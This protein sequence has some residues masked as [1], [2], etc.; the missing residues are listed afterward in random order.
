MYGFENFSG[1]GYAKAPFSIW[2]Y[3]MSV[4]SPT[5]EFWSER[6]VFITG[7]TGFKG[8]WL[9][10]W[11]H[12]LGAAV[13]GYALEPA[14][15]PNMYDYFG[16]EKLIS[17]SFGDLNDTDKLRVEMNQFAPDVVLHLAA[18]ALVIDSYKSPLETFQTNTLGTAS[19]LDACRSSESVKVIISVATDKVYEN[20][21]EM[22]QFSESDR[23][24]GKDPYSASKAAA[25]LVV[26]A[27]RESFFRGKGVKLASVRAGNV[28]GG[29][30]WA[31]NRIVPDAAR[32]F[33][34]GQGLVV[35][36]P[37]AIRPWQFVLEPLLGYLMVAKACFIDTGYDTAWNF[38]PDDSDVRTVGELADL[39]CSAWGG[40]ASWE[41]AGESPG[42]FKEASVLLLS[43]QQAKERLN[44]QPLLNLEE[45]VDL[46][47]RWYKMFQS[48][49]PA[50]LLE[51]TRT[52][53]EKFTAR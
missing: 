30:D 38:G 15:D 11:L 46:T 52:L 40:E 34:G 28:F 31:D 27:Y 49:S 6:R 42:S 23:L 53:T 45:G 3:G 50:E 39:M 35:R 29:G 37:Q 44:W 41:P 22:R 4:F 32:A 43:S 10:I 51:F 21:E 16:C 8:A 47:M 9:S 2:A 7:H 14:T 17:S 5:R 48:I 13:K 25:E 12:A 24:G 33:S 26:A 1:A 19:L 18:Q 36:N 20:L